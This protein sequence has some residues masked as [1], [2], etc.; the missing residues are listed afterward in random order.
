MDERFDSSRDSTHKET[1]Q[2]G[3]ARSNTRE[4]AF[5]VYGKRWKEEAE[6]NPRRVERFVEAEI[7]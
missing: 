7:D 2:S 5:R 3:S 6:T 4:V 1:M